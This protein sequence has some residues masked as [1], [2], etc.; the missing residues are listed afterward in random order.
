MQVISHWPWVPGDDRE[1]FCSRPALPRAPSQAWAGKS[2]DI[3]Y[4]LNSHHTDFHEWAMHGIARPVTVVGTGS[5][6]VAKS[7]GIETEV[8]ACVPLHAVPGEWGFN[9]GAGGGSTEPP[10][11]RWEEGGGWEKGSIDRTANQLL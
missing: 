6:G 5:T 7:K 3:S 10:Q 2:S 4:Y 1:C 11:T 8:P 9:W